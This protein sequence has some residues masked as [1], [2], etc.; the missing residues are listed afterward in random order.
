MP[1]CRTLLPLCHPWNTATSLERLVSLTSLLPFAC[2]VLASTRG[3][4]KNP[5]PN[6]RDV[7]PYRRRTTSWASVAHTSLWCAQLCHLYYFSTQAPAE[8][9]LLCFHVINSYGQLDVLT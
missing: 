7:C 6:R 9:C 2:V 8:E 5:Q 4:M 1:W 3:C